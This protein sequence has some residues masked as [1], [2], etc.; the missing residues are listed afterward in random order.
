MFSFIILHLKVR[1]HYSPFTK[2][3]NPGIVA[4]HWPWQLA[5]ILFQ[6]IVGAVVLPCGE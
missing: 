2:A 5:D 3:N 4:G 1:F 6:A